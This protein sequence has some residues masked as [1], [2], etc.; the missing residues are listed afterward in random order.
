MSATVA[1]MIT[2]E[3]AIAAKTSIRVKPWHHRPGSVPPAPASIADDAL[4]ARS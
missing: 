3:I 4:L 2:E 1:T